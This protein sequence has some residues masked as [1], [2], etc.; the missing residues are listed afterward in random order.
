MNISGGGI[1]G[2]YDLTQI[3]REWTFE[4]DFH[5]EE[6][7]NAEF[8]EG[9]QF[10]IDVSGGF[11]GEVS[12]SFVLMADEYP[13]TPYL[14]G[15]KFTSAQSFDSFTDFGLT[16]SSPGALTENSGQTIMEIF[17]FYDDESIFRQ[18][19]IG[20][21]TQGTVPAGTVLPGH[22][23]YGYLEFTHARIMDGTGGFEVP[24]TESRNEATDFTLAT[25]ESP[26][27]GGWSFGNASGDS[28]GVLVFL[29]NGTYF[30]YRGRS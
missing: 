8:P 27:A 21:A 18:A 22:T 17:R 30:P 9:G 10:T 28:S 16:W 14:A 25:P 2:S 4:K 24:G 15:T 11:L 20:G 23:F 6:A 12:Q 19:T 5:S 3:G 1:E 7:I 13:N 26:L 29:N